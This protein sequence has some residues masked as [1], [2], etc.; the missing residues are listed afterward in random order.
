M[1]K[2]FGFELVEDVDAQVLQQLRND[3]HGAA[4]EF[5]G[6]GY[7]PDYYESA[8]SD[9]V[10]IAEDCIRK[11]ADKAP[12]KAG[13]PQHIWS[14]ENTLRIK[15]A[16]STTKAWNQQNGV[17]SALLSTWERSGCTPITH[18]PK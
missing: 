14:P 2:P 1:S 12:H 4:E 8:A 10:R 18:R 11:I 16:L 13:C 15:S 5:L 6:S 9:F 17:W 7:V 3:M